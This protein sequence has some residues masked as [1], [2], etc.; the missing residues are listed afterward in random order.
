M[1][2]SGNII[3]RALIRDHLHRSWAKVSSDDETRPSKPIPFRQLASAIVLLVNDRGGNFLQV[4]RYQD[5]NGEERKYFLDVSRE[6]A[7]EKAIQALRHQAKQDGI[8]TG[9]KVRKKRPVPESKQTA[10]CPQKRAR[11]SEPS[12]GKSLNVISSSLHSPS[13]MDAK[14][15]LSI[16]P[17][18]AIIGRLLDRHRTVAV[19]L[20]LMEMVSPLELLPSQV[21]SDR[22]ARLASNLSSVHGKMMTPP[23]LS[24]RTETVLPPYSMLSS[25]MPS[26]PSPQT[27]LACSWKSPHRLP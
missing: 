25:W 7:I 2:N 13:K 16:A 17:Q 23:L 1:P 3:Y 27:T 15:L 21:A 18:E 22:I 14:S 24:S 8:P 5:K 11:K 9:F 19:P 26:L 10:A 4:R 6:V 12:D 20:S